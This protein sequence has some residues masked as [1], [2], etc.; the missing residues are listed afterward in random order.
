[1][2]MFAFLFVRYFFILF[3]GIKY[4]LMYFA[5]QKE[6]ARLR[7]RIVEMVAPQ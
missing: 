2:S 4:K 7:G 5:K 6:E 1:V 3:T